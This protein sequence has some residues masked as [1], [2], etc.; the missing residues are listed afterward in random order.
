MFTARRRS[1]L[2][3][4]ATVLVAVLLLAACDWTQFRYGP[5]HTSFNP[6][7]TKISPA[8]VSTV[9]LRWSQSVGAQG[10][11]SPMTIANGVVYAVADG[12]ALRVRRQHRKRTLVI[13]GIGVPLSAASVANGVVYVSTDNGLYALDA[14][15]GAKPGHRPPQAALRR[16]RT[17]WCT[18]A[19]RERA[20]RVG[21]DHRSE[22]LVIDRRRQRSDGRERCGV[23]RHVARARCAGRHYRSDALVQGV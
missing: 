7:E 17:V 11:T 8:N 6:T 16:S 19:R 15:T 5:A 12:Q 2:T 23:R 10:I 14:T 3:A 4:A 13:R 20:R 21:R 9:R 22:T 1:Q 18:S